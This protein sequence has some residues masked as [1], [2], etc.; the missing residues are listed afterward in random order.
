MRR[1]DILFS[2]LALIADYITLVVAGLLAYSARLH[3]FVT[4]LRP[5]IFSLPFSVYFS[6]VL[7]IACVWILV[8]SIA[9]LY[10]IP[11]PKRFIDILA[12]IFLGSTGFYSSLFGCLSNEN[13]LIPDLSS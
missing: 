6:T 7:G 13:C 9:G 10:T 12:K 5:V 1:S 4:E 2:V 8:F 11:E 3:P